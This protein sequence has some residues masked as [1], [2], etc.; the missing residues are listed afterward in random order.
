[1]TKFEAL[2]S[3]FN[4]RCEKHIANNIAI[5]K[6]IGGD[7]VLL[8]KRLDKAYRAN[9][10][11]FELGMARLEKMTGNSIEQLAQW[12][13]IVDQ[14]AQ[15][16]TNIKSLSK[17]VV[18]IQFLGGLPVKDNYFGSDCDLIYKS[19]QLGKKR[20]FYQELNCSVD[21]HARSVEM[22]YRMALTPDE[23]EKAING[24]SGDFSPATVPTQTSQ[25]KTLYLAFGLATGEKGRTE[26][27]I[28]FNPRFVEY[29]VRNADLLQHPRQ[30]RQG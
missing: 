7:A 14:Q 16:Y 5:G 22:S 13:E 4:T 8:V 30:S 12:S 25:L 17:L 24:G 11:S 23:M 6:A 29:V 1:M 18:I 28:S 21:K 26:K 10:K 2:R 15:K 9:P 20:G 19:Y 27:P 3:S